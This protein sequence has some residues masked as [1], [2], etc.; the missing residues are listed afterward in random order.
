[1][2]SNENFVLFSFH[3]FLV[4]LLS[5]QMLGFIQYMS[6][7]ILSDQYDI[8]QFKSQTNPSNFT[9]SLFLKYLIFR[10][11][12]IYHIGYL[13][14]TLRWSCFK[15]RLRMELRSR[16]VNHYIFAV[17]IT[18]LSYTLSTFKGTI[19]RIGLFK[20]ACLNYLF[21]YSI[22]DLPFSLIVH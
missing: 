22:C 9:F 14:L 2:L 21:Y 10:F 17:V 8:I 7:F 15:R 19:F 20:T 11:S 18:A 4:K 6:N 12:L 13:S 5:Y 1:M 3:F 16:Q